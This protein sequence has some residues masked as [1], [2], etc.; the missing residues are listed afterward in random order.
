VTPVF[1]FVPKTVAGS[2]ATALVTKHQISR[3]S[4][5][6]GETL[7]RDE[8]LAFSMP[9]FTKIDFAAAEHL[10]DSFITTCQLPKKKGSTA[11]SEMVTL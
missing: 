9:V 6:G 3:A 8:F 11:D 7:T 5:T 2:D 1:L 10:L 4:S